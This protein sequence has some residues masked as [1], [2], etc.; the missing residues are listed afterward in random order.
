MVGIELPP[1]AQTTET[2]PKNNAN[3]KITPS[4]VSFPF[5]VNLLELRHMLGLLIN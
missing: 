4:R 5:P 3:R 1:S 2:L